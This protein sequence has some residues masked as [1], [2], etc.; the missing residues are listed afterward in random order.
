MIFFLDVLRDIKFDC[1][2]T[3]VGPSEDISYKNKLIKKISNLPKNIKIIISGPITPKK[4]KEKL[5]NADIFVSS[6]KNENY[7]HSIVEAL[8]I[9]LPV[10]ISNKNPWIELN[11][12]RA[13]YR[14]PLNS[15][16]FLEKLNYFQK[17]DNDEFLKYKSGAIDYYNNFMNP[18]LYKKD[19]VNLLTNKL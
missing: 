15:N 13:G 5:L 16:L 14:I 8:S 9:G 4:V 10:L 12:Y 1:S 7:G 2:Y 3:L 11:E 17:L 19:Y 6:S 18:S